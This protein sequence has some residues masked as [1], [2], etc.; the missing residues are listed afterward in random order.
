MSMDKMIDLSKA[1]GRK[2]SEAE[3]ARLREIGDKLDLREDDALWPLLAALEY[4][5][6][7]YEALPGKIAGASKA[8]I[9]DISTAAEKEAA[10]AQARLTDCVVREAQNLASKIQIG[11]VLPLAIAALICLFGCIALSMWAGFQLGARSIRPLY[12]VLLI[13]W[14]HIVCVGCST[15]GAISFLYTMKRADLESEDRKLY[16]T[17]SILL[18]IVGLV[19]LYFSIFPEKNIFYHI[20]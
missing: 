7:Y 2:L 20:K 15:T 13:P 1:C 12:Q 14:F 19:L 16:I 17:V 9:N 6:V 11:K 8:I 18:F 3:T 10:A 4:Q 5:R